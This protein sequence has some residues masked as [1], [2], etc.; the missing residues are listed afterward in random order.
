MGHSRQYLGG[1]RPV[2][3]PVLWLELIPDPDGCIA[4]SASS[5]LKPEF[6]GANDEA[7]AQ[8]RVYALPVSVRTTNRAVWIGSKSGR[9]V[10]VG[11]RKGL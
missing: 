7:I 4:S 8:R 9:T 3:P 1:L 10:K 2:G 5:Y 11:A 6:A